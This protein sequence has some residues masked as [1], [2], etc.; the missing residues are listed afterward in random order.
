M[1]MYTL[2]SKTASTLPVASADNSWVAKEHPQWRQPL[3]GR[4]QSDPGLLPTYRAAALGVGTLR[5]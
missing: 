5:G 4:L 1:C 3:W 2:L